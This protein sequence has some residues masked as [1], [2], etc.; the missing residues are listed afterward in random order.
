MEQPWCKQNE[1]LAGLLFGLK[2]LLSRWTNLCNNNKKI[3]VE[4]TIHTGT[5]GS[6]IMYDDERDNYNYEDG[7]FATI[8]LL[9]DDSLGELTINEKKA[10]IKVCLKQLNSGL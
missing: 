2:I 8:K 7:A 3:T 5:N 9:W 10:T 4:L 1:S 6:F